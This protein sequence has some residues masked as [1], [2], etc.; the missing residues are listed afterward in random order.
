LNKN[1]SGKPFWLKQLEL[2][3]KIANKYIKN[4]WIRE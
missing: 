3:R 1:F 4:V 2:F